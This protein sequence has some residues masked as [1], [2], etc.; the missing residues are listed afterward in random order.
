[1]SRSNI[2]ISVLYSYYNKIKTMNAMCIA[3][4]LTRNV[5]NHVTLIILH[6]SCGR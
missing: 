2:K 5:V 4:Y 6:D 3:R 1:M